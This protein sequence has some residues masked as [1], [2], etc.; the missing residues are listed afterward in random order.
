M[1]EFLINFKLNQYLISFSWSKFIINFIKILI[2]WWKTH[3]YMFLIQCPPMTQ[4][5]RK[6]L[7]I[8]RIFCSRW[9]SEGHT[10][11]LGDL[12][13]LVCLVGSS[14]HF[15]LVECTLGSRGGVERGLDKLCSWWWIGWELPLAID[16]YLD[17][18]E[19]FF[20]FCLFFAV[21]IFEILH[22]LGG[23]FKFSL[24]YFSRHEFF[25]ARITITE[26]F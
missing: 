16:F 20:S 15:P 14:R 10:D 8:L 7:K 22:F 26:T 3:L 4:I 13:F 2:N 23:K 24:K 12:L 6:F 17:Y 21:V 5:R 11:C 9:G 1:K 25:K 19:T 18:K